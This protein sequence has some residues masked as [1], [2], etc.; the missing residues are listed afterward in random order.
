MAVDGRS[1]DSS[2]S[3]VD[4]KTATIAVADDIDSLGARPLV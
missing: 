2:A 3:E 1:F 4:V